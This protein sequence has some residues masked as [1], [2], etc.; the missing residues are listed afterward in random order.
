MF[1]KSKRFLAGF[2]AVLMAAS[3]AQSFAFGAEIGENA[4]QAV[5]VQ[6][7]PQLQ[8]GTAVIPEGSDK[9][10]VNEILSKALIANYD[11]VGTQEW[12]YYCT[13]KNGLL[14]NDAWLH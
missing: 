4:G 5:T 8:N 7:E 12:E 9:A 6:A 2:L 11:Q 10:A 3:A 14:T 13:G 1:R